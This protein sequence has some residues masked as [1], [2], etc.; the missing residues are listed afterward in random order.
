MNI[1]HKIVVQTFKIIL[2]INIHFGIRKKGHRD[3]QF[4]NIII[5]NYWT[6][7]YIPKGRFL[8]LQIPCEPSYHIG[9]GLSALTRKLHEEHNDTCRLSWH[10]PFWTNLSSRV[11]HEPKK[12]PLMDLRVKEKDQILASTDLHQVNVYLNFKFWN[13]KWQSMWF[14]NA[15]WMRRKMFDSVQGSKRVRRVETLGT[16]IRDLLVTS[17]NWK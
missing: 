3:W 13:L 6:Y 4:S 14:L 12:W 7:I 8:T 5:L 2:I 15:I 17:L 1:C 10:L 16:T 11:S 9:M